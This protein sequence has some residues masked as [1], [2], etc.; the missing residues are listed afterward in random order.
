[1]VILAGTTGYRTQTRSREQNYS[2]NQ[3]PDYYHE[4]TTTNNN[5]EDTELQ[6]AIQ[7]SLQES[8]RHRLAFDLLFHDIYYIIFDNI[9]YTIDQ[10]LN[11]C[12]LIFL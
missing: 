9:N 11:S 8:N 12:L 5:D 4:Y 10:F 2:Q 1:M 6:Q 3:Q 7:A